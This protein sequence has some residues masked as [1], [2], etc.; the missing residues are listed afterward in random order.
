MYILEE[1]KGMSDEKVTVKDSESPTILLS[2]I[3]TDRQ[4]WLCPLAN[5]T[6]PVIGSFPVIA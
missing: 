5:S 1:E 2:R 3:L 6:C 4:I